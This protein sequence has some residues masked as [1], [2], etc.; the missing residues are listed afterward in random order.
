MLKYQDEPLSDYF[1]FRITPS[2][3]N[4]LDRRKSP[5]KSKADIVRG[6]I[7]KEIMRERNAAAR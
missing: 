1:Q 4:W 7:D 6:L 2:Q 3:M 5:R